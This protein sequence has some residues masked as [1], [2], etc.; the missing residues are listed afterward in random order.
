MDTA[1]ALSRPERWPGKA[2]AIIHAGAI[3]AAAATLA[4]TWG[5]NRWSV[6][7]LVA[8]AAFAV[9]S[10]LMAVHSGSE[11]IKFSGGALATTLA[12]VLYGPAPTVAISLLMLCVGWFKWREAPHYFRNNFVT[13]VW[14]PLATAVFF[15]AVIRGAQLGSGDAAYYFLVLPAFAITLVVN[16]AGIVGYQSYLER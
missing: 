3:L 4:L 5:W 1:G 11:K 14:F 10:D 9:G 12:A 8:L 6:L 13:Y 15:G 7:P 2:V 16:F